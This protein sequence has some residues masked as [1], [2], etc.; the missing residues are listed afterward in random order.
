MALVGP[1]GCG[2]STT[3]QMLERFYDPLAGRVTLDGIDIRELNL[4]NYR[5]QI[6]LVSQEP[7]S[8]KHASKD[9]AE[10]LQTLYA[11]TIRFNI[12]LGANKPMEEVTQDEIDAAC[13]DANIVRLS[14]PFL[15]NITDSCF[16]T[17]LSYPCQMVLT[18]KSVGKVPNFLVVKSN[19]SLL[20]VLSFETPKSCSLMKLPLHWT[21]SPKRSFKRHLIRQP[22]VEQQLRLLIVCRQFNILTRFTTS[23]KAKWPSM[24]HTKS[25]W[26]RKEVM[27]VSICSFSFTVGD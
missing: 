2:K 22:G 14:H 12:L 26:P 9:M 17:T 27:W 18:P 6:S 23:L 21:V 10:S 11:G 7:V 5:S 20:L 13:K 16:S 19:V 8:D 4:A 3:I 1:S 25:F 15:T 24:E